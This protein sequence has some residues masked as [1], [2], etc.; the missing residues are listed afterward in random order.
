MSAPV[1]SSGALSTAQRVGSN[2]SQLCFAQ[3]C[4]VYDGSTS[5]N[6]LVTL[7]SAAG[8]RVSFNFPVS[9]GSSGLWVVPAS[10]SVNA[11]VHYR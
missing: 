7:S 1:R 10:T 2:A 8:Q 3:H 5:G 11:V 6:R 4:T 9:V